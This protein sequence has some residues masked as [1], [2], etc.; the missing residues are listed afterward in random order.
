MQIVSNGNNL[1]EMSNSDFWDNKISITNLSSSEI[2]K[3]VVNV[4]KL[5]FVKVALLLYIK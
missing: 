4:K 2:A 5:N 1:Y 3:R